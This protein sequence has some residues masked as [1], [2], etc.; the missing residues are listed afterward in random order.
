[1]DEQRKD[2][3]PVAGVFTVADYVSNPGKVIA[4]AAATG[5]AVVVRPDGTP[6]VTISIP[7]H[8]L[9]PLLV[10]DVE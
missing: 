8:D 9:P 7:T 10:E 1:M 2:S 4:Y 5:C 6:R 3:S